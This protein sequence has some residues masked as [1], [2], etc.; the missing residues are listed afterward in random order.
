MSFTE[1][2][3]QAVEF[4]KVFGRVIE[5]SGPLHMSFHM[6]QCVYNLYGGLLRSA[7]KCLDW[8][9]IKP[10]KVSDNYRLCCSLAMLVYEEL[11]RLLL[12][13]YMNVCPEEMIEN[14]R[15]G[16]G[17]GAISMAQGFLMYVNDKA[18][19][20]TDKSFVYV[21][22]YWLLMNTFRLYYDSQ[23]NGDFIL[24]EEIEDDFCGVFLLM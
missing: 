3:K 7:Q 16:E 5:L 12:F 2:F 4:Q 1:E 20:S 21:C 22:R 8:K 24:M 10:A 13:Q 6:L 19:S 17:I 14:E 18:D 11:T 9:K 23:K 15:N